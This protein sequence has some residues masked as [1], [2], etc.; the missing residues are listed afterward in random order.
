MNNN[1][2]TIHISF[3]SSPSTSARNSFCFDYYYRFTNKVELKYLSSVY[4]TSVISINTALSHQ[5][6]RFPMCSIKVIIILRVFSSLISLYLL[7]TLHGFVRV[8]AFYYY[9]KLDLGYC[10]F[11]QQWTHIIKIS[12]GKHGQVQEQQD[13]KR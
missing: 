5:I 12:P 2:Q 7:L 8:C 13:N 1:R 4:F 6:Y 9:V 10:K 11:T 3:V